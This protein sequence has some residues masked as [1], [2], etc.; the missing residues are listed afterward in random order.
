MTTQEIELTEERV[1]S[2][3]LKQFTADYDYKLIENGSLF[4]K[5]QTLLVHADCMEWLKTIPDSS[6]HAVVTDPPYGVKEYNHAEIEKKNIGKG[7]V[8]RIPPSFDGSNRA[9]LPRFTALSP[10]ERRTIEE[11][12]LAWAIEINRVLVPGAHVFLAGN[13][14]LSQLVFSAIADSGLEF[15]GEVIRLVRTF[16]GGDKPKNYEKEFPDVCT[17]PRGCYEPWGLFRKA[18]PRGM[19]V[20]DCLRQYGTGGIRRIDEESPFEDVIQSGR[21]SAREKEVA[22]HPS[23]KPQSLLRKIVYAALPTGRGVI[24]DPFAGSGSTCAAASFHGYD[25]IGVERHPEYYQLAAQAIPKLSVLPSE[26]S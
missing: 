14:F 10:A 9:P 26:K 1:L 22:N 19:T 25:T 21:T 13:A 23:L 4:A 11:F 20:G 24:L 16:R 12:F 18:M 6:I 2:D 5:G 8:W 17:L 7:G 3:R 15:R